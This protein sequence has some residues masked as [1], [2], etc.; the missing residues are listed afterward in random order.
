MDKYKYIIFVFFGVILCLIRGV[1]A[2]DDSKV[3]LSKVIYIDPGHGG[4]DC[5]AY[6]K[7]VKESDVNLEISIKL[8][9]ALKKEGATVYLTRYGDYD[10]STPGAW[11][12]KRSDLSRRA[13]VIN[14]SNCD[15]YLSIHLNADDS[16]VLH[17]AEVYYDTINPENEKI[18][19]IFQEEFNKHLSSNRDF[20]E[21]STKYL[22]RRVNRPGV[23]LEVGFLSNSSERAL[24]MSD[25]Y[26]KRLVNVIKGGIYKYFE[27]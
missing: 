1:F 15:L 25:V 14:K 21:N 26:Q 19:G 12:R 27:T 2:K 18:A 17:G 7:N 20:K 9:N 22:Q 5:G 24:L 8:M 10:L 13:N 6:Y 16:G 11:N 23:L 3:L 4:A